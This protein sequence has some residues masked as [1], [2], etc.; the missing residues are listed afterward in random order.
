MVAHP[1][2][3][4]LTTPFRC[5]RTIE[6]RSRTTDL[7]RTIRHKRLDK[8]PTQSQQH[9]HFSPE[10]SGI[11]PC[12]FITALRI[13]RGI[14]I[15]GIR[16]NILHSLVQYRT[17]RTNRKQSNSSSHIEVNSCAVSCERSG[18]D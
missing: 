13:V 7:P 4:V 5:Y 18:T 16:A 10:L 6:R 8:S 14:L 17:R 1:R 3:S 11:E 12:I 2:S 9:N 15:L